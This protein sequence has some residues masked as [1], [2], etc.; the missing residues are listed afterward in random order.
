MSRFTRHTKLGSRW[1]G[2][3]WRLFLRNPWLLGGMG[4]C[5]A[6]VVS[7]LALIPLLG[8][9]LI[10]LLAPIVLASYYLV[11]DRV[12]R[13]SVPLP[14]NLRLAAIKQSVRELFGVFH[15]EKR[16]VPMLVVSLYSMVASLLTNTFVWLVAGSAWT[17]PL[18]SL[19]IAGLL[20][21]CAAIFVALIVYFW[22][23]ISFVYA[24]PR[25]FLRGKPLFPEIGRSVKVGAHY[26]FALLT[27]LGV[28]LAP[29]LVGMTI[30]LASVRL[31]YAAVLLA[32]VVVLPLV[33]CGLYCSY[34]SIFQ[35]QPTAARAPSNDRNRYE[36]SHSPSLRRGR[37]DVRLR[38]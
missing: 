36:E 8:G 21:V 16:I 7:G 30:S 5:C 1:L 14:A 29:I 26:L 13:S 25:A 2:C 38:E 3:G 4:L 35:P 10:A 32:N 17:K 28:L 27:V 20:A 24:L 9:S 31:A 33:A 19:N 15:D 18:A 23:A 6:V 22:L 34:R 12:S 37:A 11:I